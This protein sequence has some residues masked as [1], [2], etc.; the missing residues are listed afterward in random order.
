MSRGFISSKT[1]TVFCF[2]PQIKIKKITPAR[3]LIITGRFR[4]S[5]FCS[6]LE[7]AFSSYASIVAERSQ[8]SI[9]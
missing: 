4:D 3:R 7:A 5:V 8:E 6:V 2:I 9:L 1:K